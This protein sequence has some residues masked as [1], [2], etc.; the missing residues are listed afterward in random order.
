LGS[1]QRN[2]SRAPLHFE[3]PQYAASA[4][5][6]KEDAGMTKEDAGMT[7]EDAGMTEG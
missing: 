3:M 2:I 4:G 5:M 6:T 7:E 1:E